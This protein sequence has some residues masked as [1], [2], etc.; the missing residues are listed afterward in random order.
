MPVSSVIIRKREES[1]SEAL[2]TELASVEG[3]TLKHVEGDK[4]VVLIDVATPS[5]EKVIWNTLE[6]IEGV[7]HVDLIYH[8]FEDVNE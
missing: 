2:S 6:T 5:E 7:A 8:N 3:A 1:D 4:F